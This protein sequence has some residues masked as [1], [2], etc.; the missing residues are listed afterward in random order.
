VIGERGGSPEAEAVAMLP[1]TGDMETN[2]ST[3]TPASLPRAEETSNVLPFSF[4]LSRLRRETERY[5][6]ERLCLQYINNHAQSSI[7]RVSKNEPHVQAEEVRKVQFSWTFHAPTKQECVFAR[8]PLRFVV[9]HLVVAPGVLSFRLAWL[10]LYRGQ[11]SPSFC[12]QQTGNR[13]D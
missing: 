8:L 5:D 2:E 12:R 11:T 7:S 13:V 6:F 3:D 9:C 1:A 10:M 4:D